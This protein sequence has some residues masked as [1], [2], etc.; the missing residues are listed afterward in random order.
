[1]LGVQR[2]LHRLTKTVDGALNERAAFFAVMCLTG[3]DDSLRVLPFDEIT[4]ASA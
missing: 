1:L 2:T 3:H 4:G